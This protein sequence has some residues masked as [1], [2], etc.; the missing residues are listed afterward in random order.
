M[1]K[2]HKLLIDKIQ[3]SIKS[4]WDENPLISV[5]NIFNVS[6]DNQINEN[7]DDTEEN[8]NVVK[9]KIKIDEE[10]SQIY[11]IKDYNPL[12]LQAYSL[13]N[14]QSKSSLIFALK[15]CGISSN[16]EVVRVMSKEQ[17]EDLI[18]QGK[19]FTVIASKGNLLLQQE[20]WSQSTGII[21]SDKKIYKD[22]N[23]D[24]HIKLI[25]NTN[26]SFTIL[27]QLNLNSKKQ[28]P[29]VSTLC[30]FEPFNLFD[31]S[32]NE[33]I[34]QKIES[35]A[36]SILYA[37]KYKKHI[38]LLSRM[39]PYQ[40]ANSF[41][42]LEA[43]INYEIQ[44]CIHNILIQGNVLTVDSLI[45]VTFE[46]IVE[47]TRILFTKYHADDT[48][49]EEKIRICRFIALY[50]AYVEEKQD[51]IEKYIKSLYNKYKINLEE[52]VEV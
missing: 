26:V 22:K 11:K 35:D 36:K 52:L 16:V 20:E 37:E 27:K 42:A 30:G 48:T 32:N 18:K 49:E 40:A 4:C 13:L 19:I 15:Y 8:Y 38:E 14:Q 34:K 51:N 50:F 31:L 44:K 23:A 21:A 28:I 12:I 6:S 1:E 10:D 45:K 24:V 25:L 9:D 5:D 33:Y 29:E 39:S 2:E 17:Y 7:E 46:P 43:N 47:A 3:Q 41:L